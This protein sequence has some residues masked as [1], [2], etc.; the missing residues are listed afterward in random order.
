MGTPPPRAPF[1][2]FARR[3]QLE[4]EASAERR[5]KRWF[6]ALSAIAGIGLFAWT[7]WSVGAQVLAAQLRALAPVLPLILVLAAARFLFQAAGWRLAMA[8]A[9]RPPWHEVFAAVVAGEA[10]GYF[11]WGT[12]RASR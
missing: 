6:L 2:W 12:V 8:P 7:I 11:A 10:A 5:G 4:R 1:G 3:P 9:R